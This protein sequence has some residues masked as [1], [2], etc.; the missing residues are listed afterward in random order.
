MNSHEVHA[1]E[2][3]YTDQDL[4]SYVVYKQDIEY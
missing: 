1:Q 2:H 4:I 3:T